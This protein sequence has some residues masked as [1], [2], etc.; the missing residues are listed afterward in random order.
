MFMKKVVDDNL[1]RIDKAGSTLGNFIGSGARF[2][3]KHILAF[4][5][6]LILGVGVFIYSMIAGAS[7]KKE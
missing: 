4:G 6:I 1:G 7:N 3:G 5:A 2:I